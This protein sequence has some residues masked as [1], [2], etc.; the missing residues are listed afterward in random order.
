LT[1]ELKQR[2]TAQGIAFALGEAALVGGGPAHV[3]TDLAAL[4]AVTAADVQRVLKRHVTGAHSVTIDY[5]P[6]A[7][8]PGAKPAVPAQGDA[9]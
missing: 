9:K 6:E 8:R 2:Q 7:T 1:S 3:N 4:Q 5:V